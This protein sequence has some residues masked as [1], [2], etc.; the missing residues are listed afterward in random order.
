[1]YA[2]L[3]HFCNGTKTLLEV[4]KTYLNLLKCPTQKKKYKL[5]E[6]EEEEEEEW[7][8]YIDLLNTSVPH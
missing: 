3:C 4:W 8:L 7:H 5:E 1:M 6:E 2:I